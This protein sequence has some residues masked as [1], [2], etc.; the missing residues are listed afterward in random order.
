[1]IV[2]RKELEEADDPEARRREL[3][4]EYR[5]RFANPYT[6]A[7][8]GYVDDVIEPRRTRS[9]LVSALETALTKREPKPRRK[10]G[11]IPL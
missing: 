7:E 1:S 9:V 11:N 10:H 2:F 4:A 5:E 6:A 8:R 3:I